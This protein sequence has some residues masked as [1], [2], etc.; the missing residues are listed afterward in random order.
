MEEE[1]EEEYED[2]EKDDGWTTILPYTW[3]TSDD[4]IYTS[5]QRS[6]TNAVIHKYINKCL[7]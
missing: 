7:Y 2:D 6:G 3:P 5:K 1:E 4:V